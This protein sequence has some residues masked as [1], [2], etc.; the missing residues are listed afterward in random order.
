[1]LEDPHRTRLSGILENYAENRLVLAT[2]SPADVPPLLGK[3]DALLV[4]LWAASAAGFDSIRNIDFSTAM[5]DSMNNVIE[6]DAARKA[7]RLVRVPT[8]VYVVL[9]VYLCVTAGLLGYLLKNLRQCIA[10]T[11]LFLLLTLAVVLIF[12]IDRPT[13][14]T[15]RE[16]Q[17]PM[18]RLVAS[19]RQ[20]QAGDYDRWR[21]APGPVEAGPRN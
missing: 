10:A 21:I 1:L 4:D 19:L 13:A 17:G 11:G 3:S 20:R 6:N 16:S 8:Q 7:A 18:E 2:A 15:I 5:V 14:G 12:D 9:F